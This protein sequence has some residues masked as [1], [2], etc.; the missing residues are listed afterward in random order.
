M[1]FLARCSFNGVDKKNFSKRGNYLKVL[2]K[3]KQKSPL[4]SELL[5]KTKLNLGGE[6]YYFDRFSATK[7]QF[8]RAQKP[9]M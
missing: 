5:N 1:M 7:S 9:F 4:N 8:T 2:G 6:V 3:A